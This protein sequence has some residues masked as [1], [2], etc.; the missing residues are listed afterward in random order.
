[1]YATI[2]LFFIALVVWLLSL[3]HAYAQ[4]PLTIIDH[5]LHYSV[6]S[7][8]RYV[9]E[10]A[11]TFRI[12]TLQAAQQFSQ[13]HSP[14]SSS[15][16]QF[17]VVEAYVIAKDGTRND[18]PTDSI[19]EQQ[20]PQSA[21]AP[22]FDDSKV[23]IVV[24]P[25][26]EVGSVLHL[27]T[28]RTQLKPVFP[29][30]FSMIDFVSPTFDVEMHSITLDAPASMS[31]HVEALGLSGGAV[32]PETSNT[33]RWRW[34]AKNVKAQ[35]W[36][37]GSVSPVDASPRLAVTSLPSYQ[38]AAATYAARALDK[39]TVTPVVQKLAD[40]LTRGVVD[41]RE[42]AKALYHW[43]IANIRYVAIFI[44]V[45]G[46]VPNSADSTIRNRYGDCKDHTTVLAALLA[47]KN[48]RSSPVLVNAD[49]QY[50]QPAVAALPGVFN[51]VILA[52]PEFAIYLDTTAVHA[53]FG[54]L[55]PQLFG[56]RALLI[57][58][59][60][61][62]AEEI[63]LP[64]ALPEKERVRVLMRLA[65]QSD[66]TLSGSADVRSEGS[67]GL[68]SRA[69][70]ESVPT[71]AESQV[72]GQVLSMA[73]Q[74]GTGS[75]TRGATRDLRWPH[76]YGTTFSMPGYVQLPGPGAFAVPAGV[77]SF[78]GIAA[79]FAKLGLATRTLP[80]PLQGR[81][82]EEVV[83]L[84]L[85]PGVAATALPKANTIVWKHGRYTSRASAQGST[86]TIE[87]VLELA[88][89]GPSLEPA[90]Y[91]EFRRFGQAVQRD[92]RAQIAY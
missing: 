32:R 4:S 80:M 83:E 79:T 76:T 55:S 2:R 44:D 46:V 88:L 53:Q 37:I 25:G 22:M 92:L 87:R 77:G 81:R 26:V 49:I 73:G 68:L 13:V 89:P 86:I 65:L 74:S 69:L 27:K 64:I 9:L 35:P 43:V 63:A 48:I 59:D 90:D 20:A 28:R 21:G 71:G 50:W 84:Y 33:Q 66:G 34:E 85:P 72:V 82:I 91:P 42:Q 75:L 1:V 19:L 5:R 78:S 56:K 6:E 23:R 3:S 31:L 12:E 47:A 24:Y 39:A 17:D 15:L 60:G 45:G 57:N 51:H 58:A 7:D 62:Q 30:Q 8:G 70:L 38:A 18:V 61:Q 14:Y 40:E 10:E 16:Q 52:V 36:E 29:G 41:R 67:L 54:V 11:K